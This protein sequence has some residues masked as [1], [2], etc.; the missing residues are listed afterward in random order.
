[1]GTKHTVRLSEVN[2]IIQDTEV[3]LAREYGGGKNKKLVGKLNG[4]YIVYH[5]KEV[6]LKTQVLA[7]AICQYNEI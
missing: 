6:K 5:K 4:D 2:K 1:M 3:V 7:N